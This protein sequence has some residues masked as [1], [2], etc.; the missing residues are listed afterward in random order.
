MTPAPARLLSSLTLRRRHPRW[1]ELYPAGFWRPWHMGL[2]GHGSVPVEKPVSLMEGLYRRD[3]QETPAAQD[4]LRFEA[5]TVIGH[6]PTQTG[7]TATLL[8]GFA[9]ELEPAADLRPFWTTLNAHFE[10]HGQNSDEV[11]HLQAASTATMQHLVGLIGLSEAE[12]AAFDPG[13]VDTPGRY[14]ALARLVVLLA[15]TPE[16]PFGFSLYCS[17][18]DYEPYHA[19]SLNVT[20]PQAFLA[21]QG[22]LA[23]RD[24]IVGLTVAGKDALPVPGGELLLPRLVPELYFSTLFAPRPREATRM[25][26]GGRFCRLIL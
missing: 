1:L 5:R 17:Y 18:G 6:L 15:L 21:D 19:L 12:R 4:L 8:Q 20:V 11:A 24:V 16:R 25:Y 7:A 23:E 22:V 9:E 10:K 26:A 13:P 14:A 3:R 2:L